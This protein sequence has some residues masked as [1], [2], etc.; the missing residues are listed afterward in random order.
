MA[1]VGFGPALPG[2]A[3]VPR[4]DAVYNLAPSERRIDATG[5]RDDESI[6]DP[7]PGSVTIR[8]RI[9][10]R[11]PLIPLMIPL[12]GGPSASAVQGA[13]AGR[14]ASG[15]ACLSQRQ[16]RGAS[17]SGRGVIFVMASN[18]RFH[19]ALE[20]G[21]RPVDFQSGFYLKETGDGAICAGRDLLRARSG[22]N[23]M[24]TGFSPAGQGK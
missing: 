20:R 10:I 24:I 23:C 15:P 22:L 7:P 1:A 9:I 4:A 16:I 17:I 6:G 3:A 8:R 21:C 14:G 2:A 13:A 18:S 19:A 12:P 5:E 11:I